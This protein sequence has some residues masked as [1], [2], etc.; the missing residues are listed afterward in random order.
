MRERNSS[1]MQ[2]KPAE[3]NT[4]L[5]KGEIKE[6]GIYVFSEKAS[7]FRYCIR[8]KSYKDIDWA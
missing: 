4:D 1:I 8:M 3:N 6:R 7:S 5:Q 2:N